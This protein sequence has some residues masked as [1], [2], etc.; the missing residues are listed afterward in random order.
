[1]NRKNGNTFSELL[2]LVQRALFLASNWNKF[3]IEKFK[4]EI[5]RR[6]VQLFTAIC[7]KFHNELNSYYFPMKRIILLHPIGFCAFFLVLLFF[8]SL[9]LCITM[10]LATAHFDF[11]AIFRVFCHWNRE[12]HGVGMHVVIAEYSPNVIRFALSQATSI[13]GFLYQKL[14]AASYNSIHT[15]YSNE[16]KKRQMSCL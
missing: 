7:A 3:F 11:N 4:N 9:L 13:Y 8:I 15:K 16:N 12:R 10:L 2:L 1:M 14:V 5:S 6:Y